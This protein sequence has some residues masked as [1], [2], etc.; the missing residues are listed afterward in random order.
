MP[1][2]AFVV[3]LFVL[4]TNEPLCS[5]KFDNPA[6]ALA[7]EISV[8]SRLV[9]FPQDKPYNSR[10]GVTLASV[11]AADQVPASA[12]GNYNAIMNGDNK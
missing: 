6:E 10:I 11:L 9:Q 3:C 12:I 7:M 4:A 8:N 1:P 5:D 2:V